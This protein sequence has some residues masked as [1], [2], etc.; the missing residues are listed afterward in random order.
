MAARSRSRVTTRPVVPRV[1]TPNI[2]PPARSRPP[3]AVPAVP[4]APEQTNYTAPREHPP[5]LLPPTAPREYPPLSPPPTLSLGAMPHPP[6]APM[7]LAIQKPEPAP[8]SGRKDIGGLPP[9]NSPG[10]MPHP[11]P[12]PIPNR[13]L[14]RGPASGS[15][16]TA[17][18]GAVHDTSGA[19]AASGAGIPVSSNGACSVV[20]ATGLPM[21][22]PCYLFNGSGTSTPQYFVTP[23]AANK[24]SS[25]PPA[26]APWLDVVG[27]G[28]F[29]AIGEPESTEINNTPE[30]TWDPGRYADPNCPWTDPMCVG[31]SD[32]G[33]APNVD[34]ESGEAGARLGEQ[35]GEFMRDRF[36]LP[37]L[38]GPTAQPKGTDNPPPASGSDPPIESSGPTQNQP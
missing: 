4:G 25:G 22:G 21:T 30:Q 26:L 35:F 32:H 28:L 17:S 37:W 10:Q 5:L 14:V 2:A 6:P 11:Q 34:F 23:S 33:R 27:T 18:T 38:T 1:T 15:M 29:D 31:F 12:T 8:T 19:G 36:I 3:I 13:E 9:A 20:G 24:T 7:P 16:Q